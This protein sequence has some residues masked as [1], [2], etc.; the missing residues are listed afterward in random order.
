[1]DTAA[2]AAAGVNPSAL[3]AGESGA[4][5]A[6][7]IAAQLAKAEQEV[8]N[9]ATYAAFKEKEAREAAAAAVTAI[10]NQALDDAERARFRAMTGVASAA[11]SISSGNLMAAPVVNITVQGSVTSEQDLVQTVRNGLLKTQYNGNSIN[12]QAI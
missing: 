11:S 2:K 10:N 6:A 3:A 4:I 7:S 8:K 9:A 1:M 5:G 12:L